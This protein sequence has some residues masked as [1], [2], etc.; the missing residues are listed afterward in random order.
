VL[1]FLLVIIL[2]GVAVYLVVRVIQRRGIMPPTRKKAPPPRVVGPDDDPDFL[3]D[4]D[5]DL[6]KKKRHPDED[7]PAP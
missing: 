3:R 5:T 4:L 6:D 2:F 1:K 7:D